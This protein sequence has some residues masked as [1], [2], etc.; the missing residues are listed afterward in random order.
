MKKLIPFAV[1]LTSCTI[2]FQNIDT[3]G[4]ATDLVDENQAA[5]PTVSP[6]INVPITPGL[7]IPSI[8][9]LTTPSTTK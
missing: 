5:S 4:P 3:H 8:S 2:S 9:S 7:T 1:I 6:N